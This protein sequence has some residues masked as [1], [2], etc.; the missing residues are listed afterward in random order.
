[1]KLLPAL[2]TASLALNAALLG[3]VVYSRVKSPPAPARP[4]TGQF[5]DAHDA[6]SS[7]AG[8][9]A[10]APS[11]AR[12]VTALTSG[13]PAAL[14]DQLRALGVSETMVRNIVQAIIWQPYRE[15]ELQIN[16]A[17]FVDDQPYWR[18]LRQ[19]GRRAHTREEREELRHL[20][21]DI[22]QK[23]EEVLGTAAIDGISPYARRYHFLPT[24]AAEK[25]ADIDRDY[26]EMLQEITQEAERF[27]VPSD[28]EKQRFLSQERLKDIEAV[29]TPEEFREFELR[30][31]PAAQ[32][33]RNRLTQIEV[34]EAEYRVLFELQK[35]LIEISPASAPADVP[36]EDRLAL[37]GQMVALRKQ[38]RDTLGDERFAQFMR[39]SNNEYRQLQAAADR[40]SLP[41]ETIN[42]VYGYRHDI[43]SASQRIA[44]DEALSLD[45]K[46]AALHS[47]A[48][49]TRQKISTDLGDEIANAYLAKNMRWLER[50]QNG[51]VLT[52]RADGNNVSVNPLPRRAPPPSATP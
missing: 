50:V 15:R 8:S 34:T 26:G 35:S 37:A 45:Q 30:Q 25:I 41:T 24:D 17:K 32:A 47:L 36:A 6:T 7:S 2:F 29:L 51:E 27:R 13:N 12:L 46:K 42:R 48:L 10:S 23:I 43:A 33:L 21:S 20:A 22:R 9:A 3:L 1:M 4:S 38:V 14:R 40:F 19:T 11:S 5:V 16:S 44:T 18:G 52:L 49:E 31:S 28:A 39:A